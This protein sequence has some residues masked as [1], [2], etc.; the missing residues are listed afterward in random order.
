METAQIVALNYI[1]TGNIK[2]SGILRTQLDG[3]LS[4]LREPC[5]YSKS[6]RI[7]SLLS[8]EMIRPGFM[9]KIFYVFLA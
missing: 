9:I 8:W 2:G 1:V 4:F 5:I 3:P 7:W 6:N